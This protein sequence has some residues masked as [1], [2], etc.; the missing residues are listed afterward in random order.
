MPGVIELRVVS[1]PATAQ[2]DHE[3]TELFV[4]EIVPVDVRLDQLGDDVRPGFR[5]FAASCI[6]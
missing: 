2:Q 4:G 6:A 1:L 5:P 3:E